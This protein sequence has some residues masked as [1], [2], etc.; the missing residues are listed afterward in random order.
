VLLSKNLGFLSYL[1]YLF[2]SF[3]FLNVFA[4]NKT[5][6]EHISYLGEKFTFH[7]TKPLEIQTKGIAILV[8]GFGRSSKN[9][10]FQAERMQ[11]LGF[12]TVVPDVSL[13]QEMKSH[14]GAT[15]AEAFS[16]FQSLS[17]HKK[18]FQLPKIVIGHSAGAIWATYFAGKLRSLGSDVRGV[19]LVD[20]VVKK[21]Y[22]QGFLE[23]LKPLPKLSL[24]APPN[25]C[26]DHNSALTSILS[27]PE[28]F[29]GIHMK[30]GSHCDIEG[31]TSDIL[32]H[33]FCGKS[34]EIVIQKTSD[35]VTHWSNDLFEKTKEGGYFPGG[36][37]LEKLVSDGLAEELR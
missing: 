11:K 7:V 4:D 22:E 23:A 32:C 31:S 20:P 37:E 6:S 14:T 33:T 10:K 18:T 5:S 3:C 35:V 28:V 8:H 30:Q 15:F 24:F 17:E 19:V 27:M 34:S 21:E 1:V 2:I 25:S 36:T 13:P 9:M 26:N 12:L 16:R 29:F